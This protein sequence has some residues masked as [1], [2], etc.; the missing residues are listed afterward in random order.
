MRL[1][2]LFAP[3]VLFAKVQLG[4]DAFFEDGH[5]Q[6]LKAKR[7]VLV[8][9]HT[10]VDQSMRLSAD[11]F[12]D[13]PFKLVA[14]WT[15][16][17]GLQGVAYASEKVASSHYKNVAVQSLYGE[18]KRPTKE[19]LSGVDAIVYDIQ[20]IGVR[21][22]TFASTL[23]MVME[24][25]AEAKV[26]VIVLD[27]PNPLGGLLVDGPMLSKALRSVV[28]YVNVPYCHGMTI[29][30]LAQYFNGEYKVGCTLKVVPM[31]G[32]RRAMS[33]R[34]T[35][36][37]WIP[38]SPHVPEMDTPL[39]C[40]TTGIL[41]E[42]SVVNIGVGYT[43]PFKLVGAPW[44]DAEKFAEA[45]NAQKLSGVHFVP[46]HY[47]PFYGLY[48]AQNCH[49]VL[50]DITDSKT[51]RPLSTGYMIMGLLKS[52]YPKQFLSALSKASKSKRDV[53][54]KVNGTEVILKYLLSDPYPAW[55]CISY[56]E[57]ERVAFMSTRAKYLVY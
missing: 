25:A 21:S 28:G 49:G 29:G 50:V 55:K 33:F 35:A 41:G 37:H 44:I 11:R 56:Q 8:T 47:R 2:L 38:T 57:K 7:V 31:K 19:M 52:L 18:R 5:A 54:N 24:A 1:F 14:L 9:N 3:L 4:I 13:A 6:Q 17:H 23:Y 15:P 34:D 45:L 36:L 26:P 53:F 22:Y 30:E 43:L 27:R 46:F 10:A 40:A 51:F 32:W 42:L 16:E 48:K 39:Y 20:D 12:L